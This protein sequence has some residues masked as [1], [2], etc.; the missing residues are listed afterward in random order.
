MDTPIDDLIA[1]MKVDAASI[2]E[3]TPLDRD[4]WD[5]PEEITMTA[6]RLAHAFRLRFE[7]GVRAQYEKFK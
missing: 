7:E 3:R 2:A 5:D 4:E 1:Q 6:V